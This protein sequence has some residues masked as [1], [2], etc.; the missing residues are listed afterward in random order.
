MSRETQKTTETMTTRDKQRKTARERATAL[1]TGGGYELKATSRAGVYRV[2]TPLRK[3]NGEFKKEEYVVDVI[4]GTCTCPFFGEHGNCKHHMGL[5]LFLAGIKM[6]LKG[7]GQP[8][9]DIPEP[10]ADFMDFRPSPE[11]LAE[12]GDDFGNPDDFFADVPVT[13]RCTGN[14]ASG[15]WTRPVTRKPNTNQFAEQYAAMTPE[16]KKK[17]LS[18]D[19][20]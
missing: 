5:I 3:V 15:T 17:Q 4:G 7:I 19:W 14:A 9:H 11:Q 10:R 16:Q 18:A 2:F 6:F 13:T 12:E 1:F 20:D 8:A